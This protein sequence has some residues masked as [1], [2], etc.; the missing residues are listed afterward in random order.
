MNDGEYYSPIFCFSGKGYEL[1]RKVHLSDT[2]VKLHQQVKITVR[3]MFVVLSLHFYYLCYIYEE[4][5]DS[6]FLLEQ[7][8]YIT[9]FS[10]LFLISSQF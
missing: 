10:T 1:L 9:I 3:Q 8:H 4:N 5:Y 7:L 6:L 2:K